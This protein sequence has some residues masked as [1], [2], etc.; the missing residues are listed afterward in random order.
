MRADAG[1]DEAAADVAPEY[2][3]APVYG[4]IYVEASPAAGADE[5]AADVA[6]EYR[7]APVYGSI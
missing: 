3:E 2:R 5:A 1:A 7:E 6:P 4:S